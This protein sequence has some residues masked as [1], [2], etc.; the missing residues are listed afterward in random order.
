MATRQGGY[1]LL[2]QSTPTVWAAA[3]VGGKKEGLGPLG[4]CFD[5]TS[6]D[7]SFGQKSWEAAESWMQH[8]ALELALAKGRLAAGDLNCIFAGDLLNQCTGTTFGL[9]ELGLPFV[10]V[11]GACSTM[12]ESLGLAALFVE[13]GF[14][15]H[16]A[17]VTSS[18]FCS[19]ERQF[20]FPLEYGGQRPPSAQ[21]TATAAG[22]AIVGPGSH[23]PYLRAVTFGRMVDLG[24]CDANNMGAAMAPAAADTLCRFFADTGTRPDHFD[25]IATGDLG[26]IGST[27]LDQLMQREGY[28]ISR[29]H[30]DCGLLLFDREQF[31]EVGAGGSGCGCSA[32]VLCGSFVPRLAR[33]ELGDLLFVATGALMSPTSSQQGESIPGVAHLV[34]LSSQRGK[35]EL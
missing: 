6:T 4:S 7:N 10:G 23:P 25:L 30:T 2:L 28:D 17:A 11:Y 5:H 19:A 24:I 3:A 13:G 12:A 34:W 9:R 26:E 1:T 29:Q 31:P 32:S 16:A 15:R 20:R 18:H 35:E 21:W 27:L 22:A 14:A 33:G 8:K